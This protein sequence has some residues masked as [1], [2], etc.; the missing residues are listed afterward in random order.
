MSDAQQRTGRGEGDEARDGD[1]VVRCSERLPGR[2]AIADRLADWNPRVHHE[3]ASEALRLAA[4]MRDLLEE[5][6][7]AVLALGLAA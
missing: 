7:A 2:E 4:R 5:A 6:R 1:V 3:Q